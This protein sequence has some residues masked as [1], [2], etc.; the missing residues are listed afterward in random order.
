[1]I[2][3]KTSEV[4]STKNS[5]LKIVSELIGVFIERFECIYLT[6]DKEKRKNR[7]LFKKSIAKQKVSSKYFFKLNRPFWYFISIGSIVSLCI[8]FGFR[9]SKISGDLENILRIVIVG[10]LITTIAL[11]LAGMCFGKTHTYAQ[12]TD[13]AV[14]I[15]KAQS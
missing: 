12:E 9:I 8:I 10:S 6:Y 11:L 14:I 7:R 5:L 15:P 2:C 4:F 13:N 3:G 1:M